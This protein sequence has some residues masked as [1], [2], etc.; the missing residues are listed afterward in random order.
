MPF[1]IVLHII[2]A[3]IALWSVWVGYRILFQGKTEL[4]RDHEH[5][6]MPEADRVARPYAFNAMGTGFALLVLCAASPL[7]LP[8]EV[9]MGGVLV[10]CVAT[11]LVRA[12]LISKGRDQ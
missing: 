11:S 8:F 3:A 2:V 5:K 9:W 1:V 10:V 12:I 4:V 7:G 6:S